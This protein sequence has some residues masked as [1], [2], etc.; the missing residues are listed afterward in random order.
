MVSMGFLNDLIYAQAEGKALP[1]H[2]KLTG[3]DPTSTYSP[4]A[5]T[6]ESKISNHSAKRHLEAYG[7]SE[8]IDWVATCVD[9]YAETVASATFHLEDA[10]GDRVYL[11]H[12]GL[13]PDDGK[14]ADFTLQTL[15]SKPNPYM[16]WDEFIHLLIVD[17][18]L[19]GN[20]YW[21]KYGTDELGKPLAL[22]RLAPAYVDI[23]PDS[24]GP[25]SYEYQPPG[26]TEPL[27]INPE[28]IVHFRRPN[29]HNHYYGMGLVKAGG[30]MFDIEIALTD[31]Q[32]SYYEN[33][34]EPSLIISSA[35]RIPRDVRNKLYSSFRSRFSGSSRTGELMVLEAGLSADTISPGAKDALFD[36]LTRASRDRIFAMFR[37]SPLL[38][39]I[40]DES[41][42]SNDPEVAQRIFDNKVMKPFMDRLAD[43]IT[44]GLLEPWGYR[45]VFDYH[46]TVPEAELLKMGGNLA[47]MPG[48]KVKE[49][50]KMLYEG[51]LVDEI[52]TGD[53]ALDEYVLNLP[54]DD[55]DKNGQGG[56]AD[57]NLPGEAGRPPLPENTRG[58]GTPGVAGGS[59]GRSVKAL[60]E[61]PTLD[62]I[63]NRLNS[64][65]NAARPELEE[66]KAEEKL[67]GSQ[68]PAD[69]LEREREEEI[70]ELAREI[71][72][73]ILDIMHTVE[74]DLLDH[75]EG[76]SFNPKTLVSRLRNS[77]AWSKFTTRMERL[78]K[79]SARKAVNI[80][81]LQYFEAYGTSATADVDY[82]KVVDGLVHREEGLGGIA[83]NLKQDVID[84]V[85]AAIKQDASKEDID[86]LVRSILE[87]WR[88]SHAET[89]ALSEAVTYYN[90]GALSVLEQAG[91]SRVV[92]LDGH[93]FDQPCRDADGSIWTI[94][95]ARKSLIEHPRCRRAFVPLASI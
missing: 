66:G 37:I 34:A 53:E 30:R 2:P 59:S 22:Y 9:Y 7:G 77:T 52:E 62:D 55:M 3:L 15:F 39:G 79:E 94:I 17:Y 81:A 47:A 49:I 45:M 11:E 93:D 26:V 6:S 40:V 54:G 64:I 16:E 75:N 67:T 33:K 21:Y 84:K 5:G 32:A 58:F 90:E 85:A 76:K 28:D 56:I 4:G 61:T 48:I 86:R 70:D 89:I 63:L 43:R 20:A 35:R 51:G 36:V 80:A 95:E 38:L 44:K 8:S 78:L 19:V 13:V 42:V 71:R 31:T 24:W 74:R 88:N 27:K 82:T 65:N 10:D 1:M 18:L 23:I 14:I 12:S 60:N 72:S 25:K 41:A 69:P 83:E 92:V 57:R 73:E 87:K 68:Y 91:N 29:P 46:Y 50:R